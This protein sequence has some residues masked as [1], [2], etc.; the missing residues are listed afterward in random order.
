MAVAKKC[1]KSV[2]M[3]MS[4][5]DFCFLLG[6]EIGC[7]SSFDSADFIPSKSSA[8]EFWK[9]PDNRYICHAIFIFS[10]EVERKME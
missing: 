8:E 10:I 9:K 1:A 2:R 5:Y 7:E 3:S 6:L 4:G